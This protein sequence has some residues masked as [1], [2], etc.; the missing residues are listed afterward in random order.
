MLV[1]SD[2]FMPNPDVPLPSYDGF[3]LGP[4]DLVDPMGL[5]SWSVLLAGWFLVVPSLPGLSSMVG[6]AF[7]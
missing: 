6:I 2:L 1:T 7:Q 3:L 5:R 4:Y